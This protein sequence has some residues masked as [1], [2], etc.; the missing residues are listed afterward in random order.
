PPV[1]LLTAD[2]VDGR[3][4][5]G[6]LS[7]VDRVLEPDELRAVA[8]LHEEELDPGEI[9]VRRLDCADE[10]GAEDLLLRVGGSGYD[11]PVPQGDVEKTHL[12]PALGWLLNRL[13]LSRI[14]ICHLFSLLLTHWKGAMI[15]RLTLVSLDVFSRPC[16]GTFLICGLTAGISGRCLSLDPS[17][18]N[19]STSTYDFLGGIP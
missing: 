9:G 8:R 17:L 4:L 19:L 6:K 5:D 1:P 18:G 13:S 16:S 11:Y 3:L 7:P 14:G 10:I 15:D 2:Q 12:L